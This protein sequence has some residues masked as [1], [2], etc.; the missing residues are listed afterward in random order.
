MDVK[1][2]MLN[3]SELL[4]CLVFISCSP[5][6]LE[7]RCKLYVL[8]CLQHRKHKAKLP[9]R[10]ASILM[11]G[12]VVWDQN[13][14]TDGDA[15]LLYGCHVGP[16]T[17]SSIYSIRLFSFRL[18]GFL[19]RKSEFLAFNLLSCVVCVLTGWSARS[20]GMSPPVTLNF[21]PWCIALLQREL[22][23]NT[24]FQVCLHI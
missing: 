11:L 12:I 15:C 1:V 4:P 2:P 21:Y 16:R 10:R 18:H 6:W 20:F 7:Y 14:R 9:H 5:I 17:S 23:K 24:P 8:Q 19:F 3:T 22:F 13:V